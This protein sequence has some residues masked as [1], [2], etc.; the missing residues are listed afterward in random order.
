MIS[1][2]FVELLEC[3]AICCDGCGD[4]GPAFRGIAMHNGDE[5]QRP[6]VVCW[7]CVETLNNYW[8]GDERFT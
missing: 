7:M 5:G 1:I 4:G 3:S 8:Q 6:L 2:G